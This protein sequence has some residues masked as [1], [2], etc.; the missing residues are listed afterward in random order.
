MAWFRDMKLQTR[1]LL[2]FSLMILVGALGIGLTLFRVNSLSA[3]ITLMERDASEMAAL[4]EVQKLLLTQ[5]KAL[6][7]YAATGDTGYLTHYEEARYLAAEALNTARAVAGANYSDDMTAFVDDLWGE[8]DAYNVAASPIFDLDLTTDDGRAE[9]ATLI[10]DLDD[11]A[12]AINT[13]LDAFIYDR[14]LLVEEDAIAGRALSSSTLA[15]G[16]VLL[17][18]FTGLAAVAALT[19]N[20]IAEPIFNLTNAIVAFENKAYRPDM[21][22]DYVER[23]DEPGRLA[24]AVDHMAQSIGAEAQRREALLNAANRF[25]PVSYLDFLQ[26]DSIADIN[27]GDHVSAEM[28]IMFTD[29]RSFSA[30]SEKMT[31]AE[32]FGFINDYLSRISPPIREHN[33]AL[34]KFVGDG[35]MSVY[36][37]GVQDAVDAAIGQLEVVAKYNSERTAQGLPSTGLGVGLHIGAMMLGMVGEETRMQGDA[38][39]DNVNLTSR[40]EGLNK[41]FGTNFI[42]SQELYDCLPDPDAISMR[43]LAKVQVKG[44]QTPITV[45]EVLA[46]DFTDSDRFK[47]EMRQPFEQALQHYWAGALDAALPLFEEVATCNPEDVSAAYY[48]KEIQRVLSEGKPADWDGVV[49]MVSK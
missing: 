24:L 7:D 15:I 12:A 37:Y 44:R 31:A 21:L 36:P 11:Q 46:G 28:A 22:A 26:K 19:T 39:S 8:I 5:Q 3:S 42:L 41:F 27:L 29:I 49:V 34:V 40:I 32:N 38:F 18:A 2:V 47:Q 45:Y 14:S 13:E 17:L 10:L 30:M 33:G 16:V 20:S 25:V 43:L 35:M 23:K 6:A 4:A 9:A 48:F 1:L